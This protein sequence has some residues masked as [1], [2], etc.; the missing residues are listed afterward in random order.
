MGRGKIVIRRIDNSTSRQVTFSKRRNGLLKKAKELS[1]LCDAEVGLIIFS[2][3]GKLYDFASTSMKSV[4]ERYNKMKEE[5]HQLLNPMSEVK[6]W[7]REAANLRQQLQYLQES[8]RQ[9]LGKELSGLSIKDLTNL[10]N[11]LEVSLKGIR[12]RK[13]QILTDEIKELNRKGSLVHQENMELCKNLNLIRQ[14]NIELQN[15]VYG[16]G[17]IN[18]ANGSARARNTVGNGY[19][20]QVPINLQLSPPQTNI[21]EAPANSMKLG[22]QLH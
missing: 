7:Q 3:T 16:P 14:E 6:F 19:D 22:L 2:S 8:H 4:I 13:E 17:R 12:T 21:N 11:Q 10:E 1:I 18:E 5:H 15:K 20:L 9:L